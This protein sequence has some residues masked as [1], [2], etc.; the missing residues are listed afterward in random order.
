MIRQTSLD[1]YEQ[2]QSD[3]TVTTQKEL[4]FQTLKNHPDGFTREDL[5]DFLSMMYTSVCGRCRT[6]IKEGLIYESGTRIN[7]SGK[8][9]RILK[10][11][12]VNIL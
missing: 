1:C 6:L 9:A 8:R 4:I 12:K 5:R 11:M 3:G 7:H 2:I 10:A